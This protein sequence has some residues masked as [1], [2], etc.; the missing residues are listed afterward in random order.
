MTNTGSPD[1]VFVTSLNPSER[2]SREGVN[3]RLQIIGGR[4][5]ISYVAEKRFDWTSSTSK[6][7][8]Q[9]SFFLINFK[10]QKVAEQ[11]ALALIAMNRLCGAGERTKR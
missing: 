5:S 4:K 11:V 9:Q 6:S 10:D 2:E 8:G 7:Q 3:L 1:P